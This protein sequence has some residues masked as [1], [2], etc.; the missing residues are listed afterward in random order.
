SPAVVTLPGDARQD[1][2]NIRGKLV[3]ELLEPSD[4]VMPQPG[5]IGSITFSRRTIA[6]PDAGDV[7]K[8]DLLLDMDGDGL[9]DRLLCSWPYFGYT[10]RLDGQFTP[11]YRS[12]QQAPLYAGENCNGRGVLD[13]DGDGFVN[14]WTYKP[15]L[16]KQWL[17]LRTLGLDHNGVIAGEWSKPAYFG[18]GEFKPIDANG[19]G[20][21]DLLF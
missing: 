6:D 12:L 4:F 21:Q 19:D 5:G 9:E 15:E 13:L 14:L 2:F 7:R 10:E 18:N 17:S 1:L 11:F 16:S 3:D 8:M 20:L